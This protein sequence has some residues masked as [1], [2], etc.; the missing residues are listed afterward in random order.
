M[1]KYQYTLCRSGL[2]VCS[3]FLLI[4]VLFCAVSCDCT[5]Y[6]VRLRDG[7]KLNYPGHFD[8]YYYYIVMVPLLLPVTVAYI[9]ANWFSMKIFK[10]NSVSAV[11]G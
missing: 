2:V 9:A 10:H 11:S 7:L 6:V 8:H 5:Q 3:A 1:H 4:L